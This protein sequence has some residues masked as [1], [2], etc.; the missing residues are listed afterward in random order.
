M[1]STALHRPLRSSVSPLSHTIGYADAH[2][3]MRIV[4]RM[5]VDD[6][7]L[8]ARTFHALLRTQ[9]GYEQAVRGKNKK[10]V[11]WFLRVV[12]QLSADLVVLNLPPGVIGAVLLLRSLLSRKCAA[13]PHCTIEQLCILALE[14]APLVV[15]MASAE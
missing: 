9:Q 15:E 14:L 4:S 10:R 1:S 6:A 11:R 12:P 5:P 2:R 13:L 3:F 7:E 8:R